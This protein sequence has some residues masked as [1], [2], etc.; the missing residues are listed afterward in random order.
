MDLGSQLRAALAD[1]DSTL[2]ARGLWAAGELGVSSLLP[3]VRVEL[4]A[5]EL[6]CRIA[7]CASTWLL[8]GAEEASSSLR[9]L[10][11]LPGP[12][13]DSAARIAAATLS[14]PELTAWSREMAKSGRHRLA[15]IAAGAAGFAASLPDIL[16]WMREPDAA[17][18]AGE[19]V[20]MITGLACSDARAELPSSGLGPNEDADDEDVS[21]HPD[22]GLITPDPEAMQ[23]ACSALE[24]GPE[25]LL[26]GHPRTKESLVRIV[27][28][29]RQRERWMAA[30]L[31]ATMGPGGALFDVT[32]RAPW[33][34]AALSRLEAS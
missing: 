1:S 33:Q 11:Q 6:E 28:S 12:H 26:L 17:R 5:D 4:D 21:M 20:T 32:A 2:R 29:G 23:L 18:A 19:A 16:S 27:R 24:L 9:T 8:G 30:R 31:L 34:L 22:Q 25:K 10:V 15:A 13:V 3:A 7:A 14:L